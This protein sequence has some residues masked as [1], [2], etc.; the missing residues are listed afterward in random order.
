MPTIKKYALIIFIVLASMTT[1]IVFAKANQKSLRAEIESPYKWGKGTGPIQV[2]MEEKDNK[3]DVITLEGQI[4]TKLSSVSI[5]WKLPEGVA[6][7]SGHLTGTAEQESEDN[8]IKRTIT[9]KVV[10]PLKK[11]HH[12]VVLSVFA[13]VNGQRKGHTAVYNLKETS[14]EKEKVEQI[15]TQMKSRGA[16]PLK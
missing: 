1:Y 15:R 11:D 7:A 12:H 8:I 2:R 16:R 3:G 13:E 14:E 10:G 4:Y 6:L 9:V 5:E